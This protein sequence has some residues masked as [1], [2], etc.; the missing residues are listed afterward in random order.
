MEM[1]YLI[2]V[3]LI[4]VA[5]IH[6][7]PL[8]GLLGSERLTALYGLPFDEPNLAI[9]MRHRAVLFGLLGLFMLFAA[10]RPRFQALAFV[11]GFVSVGSFLLLAWSTGGLNAQMAR[12]FTA[13]IVALICLF[14]GVSALIYSRR[15]D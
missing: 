9:L 11:A 6:L 8:S 5:V 13:D 7:L 1:R 3:M 14:I 10:F 15:R 2:S 4:I 12:V